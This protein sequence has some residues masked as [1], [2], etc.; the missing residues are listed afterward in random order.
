MVVKCANSEIADGALGQQ[1]PQPDGQRLVVIVLA[2]QDDAPRAIPCLQRRPIPFHPGERRL[3]HQH[4][5]PRGQR[6][7]REIQMKRRRHRDDDG[8]HLRI[9]DGRRI[10]AVAARTTVAGRKRRRPGLVPA[11]VAGLDDA[12]EG[13]QMAAVDPGDEAATEKGD[14][15]HSPSIITVPWLSLC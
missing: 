10:V 9:G 6:L 2:D 4:V 7:Q 12:P 3:L 8:I 14:A 13:L 15:Q 11:G 5:L 1:S